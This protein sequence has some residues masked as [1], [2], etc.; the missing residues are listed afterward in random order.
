MILEITLPLIFLSYGV[1]VLFQGKQLCRFQF[2]L[3]YILGSSHK[4]ENLL[5]SEQILSFKSRSHFRKT[6]S[7][8]YANRKSRRKLSPFENMA[9]KDGGVPIHLNFRIMAK[10]KRTKLSSNLSSC[11]ICFSVILL[12]SFV[13]Y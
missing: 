2:C 8:R 11:M 9:E 13:S 3:T 4:G 7:S 5:P 6:S 1:W 12:Y 10:N